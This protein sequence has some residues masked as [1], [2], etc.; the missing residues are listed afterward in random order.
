MDSPL[1]RKRQAVGPPPLLTL[2]A[3]YM[4][5]DIPVEVAIPPPQQS[6]G[7]DTVPLEDES[8]IDLF[9]RYYT[10]ESNPDEAPDPL[11]RRLKKKKS[12]GGLTDR[13]EARPAEMQDVD[14]SPVIGQGTDTCP[15]QKQGT[16]TRPAAKQGM[17]QKPVASLRMSITGQLPRPLGKVAAIHAICP[18]QWY[19]ECETTDPWFVEVAATA[20]NTLATNR[21]PEQCGVYRCHQRT[22]R[23]VQPL[24]FTVDVDTPNDICRWIE[25]WSRNP[26]GMPRA[27]R[28]EDQGRLNED[29]LDV[30]LWYR[31]I[32]RRTKDPRQPL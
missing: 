30:W 24:W 23:D 11:K 19:N 31:S 21:T 1:P 29:D 5:A 2:P 32:V 6:T 13:P 17:T 16:T 3:V 9:N 27:I 4:P 10:S 28:E 12:Q 14:M 25:E 26:I 15:V 22:L 18:L 20:A 8:T 7:I